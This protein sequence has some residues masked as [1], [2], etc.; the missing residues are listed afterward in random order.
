MQGV[1]FKGRAKKKEP[2]LARNQPAS[3]L[4]FKRSRYSFNIKRT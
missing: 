3:G 2:P 4:T 1:F